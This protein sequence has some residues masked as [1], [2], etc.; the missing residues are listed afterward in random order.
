MLIL[1]PPRQSCFI[2]GPTDVAAQPGLVHYCYVQLLSSD[3]VLLNH[4][5][6][7]LLVLRWF[8]D[9]GTY[10]SLLRVAVRNVMLNR[11]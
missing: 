6:S 10:K 3:S 1:S 11:C 4:P 2:L 8:S 7:S 9:L 5:V